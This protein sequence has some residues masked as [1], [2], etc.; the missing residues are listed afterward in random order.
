VER[1]VRPVTPVRPVDVDGETDDPETQPDFSSLV[2]MVCDDM[3]ASDPALEDDEELVDYSSS[4]E[5][6]N[7]DINVIHMSIGGYVLSEDDVAVVWTSL[8]PPH[9][10]VPGPTTRWAPGTTRLALHGT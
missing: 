6:M 5:H 3:S 7:L 1:S 8:G 4:P 10:R 9:R 2:P